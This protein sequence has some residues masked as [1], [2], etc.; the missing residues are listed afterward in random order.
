MHRG[1]IMMEYCDGEFRLGDNKASTLKAFLNP[2]DKIEGAERGPSSDAV[3]DSVG[4]R[5]RTFGLRLLSQQQQS[6]ILKLKYSCPSL[7]DDP[8]LPP[9]NWLQV[10]AMEAEQGVTF[11]PLLRFYLLNISRQHALSASRTCI[12]PQSGSDH[13]VFTDSAEH[14]YYIRWRPEK[15]M[16]KGRMSGFFLACS[17]NFRAE[18]LDKEWK[19]LFECL[20]IPEA[21]DMR[22]PTKLTPGIAEGRFVKSSC[23]AVLEVDAEEARFIS[24]RWIL[25]LLFASL[26]IAYC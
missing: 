4:P 20:L 25:L 26:D 11:P 22:C 10:L 24:H 8:L 14:N 19:T 1:W 23:F 13:I 16:L 7:L 5:E 3:A 9:Y 6:Q 21:M 17:Y 12:L 15:L 2:T 18:T